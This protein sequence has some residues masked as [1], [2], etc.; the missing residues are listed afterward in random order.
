MYGLVGEHE[1]AAEYIGNA[2]ALAEKN[3]AK[4]HPFLGIVYGFAGDYYAEINNFS[5]HINYSN[6]AI[7]IFRKAYG[8][9]SAR[10]A[11]ILAKMGS[12]SAKNKRLD[13][14]IT[15]YDQALAIYESKMGKQNPKTAS[16]HHALGMVFDDQH[17]F[18]EA[19]V[20]YQKAFA[21]ISAS[22]KDTTSLYPNPR[23]DEL[24]S[25]S[26]ALKIADSKGQT[27]FKK[28][29]FEKNDHSALK[30]SLTTYQFAVNLIDQ[31]NAEYKIE[32]A[33]IAL[34]NESRKI[35]S[36]ALRVAHQLYVLTKDQMFLNEAFIISEKSKSALLSENLRDGRAKTIAGVPD[37][38]IA[39]ENDIKVELAFYQNGMYQA[40]KTNEPD[41]IRM[42]EKNIFETQQKYN[43][44][45]E[46]LEERF[47]AYFNIKYNSKAMDIA[48]VRDLLP[49]ENTAVVE[50]FT[51]DSSVFIFSI[52]KNSARLE[53]RRRS[54]TLEEVFHNYR[55]SLTDA[56][57]IL[58]FRKQADELYTQSAYSLYEFLLQPIFETGEKSIQK[59][60]I[61]PDDVLAQL[62]FG[63]LLTKKTDNENSEYKTLEYL[64]QKY[65]ISYAYSAA[66]IRNESVR[67]KRS[68]HSFAGFAPSYSG[69]QFANL[70]TVLHSMAYLV[71]R[72]GNLSLPGAEEEV[73]HISEFMKGKSWLRENATETNFKKHAGDYAILHLAMHS[74]LNNENPEY[75]ELLFHQEKDLL[76]DG[77][78]KVSEIYNLDLNADLVVLSACSSGY[79]RIQ[80]GEG[81]ISISRA[82][83]Y[84]GCPS[85]V[86]SLWKVP[87]D[88]TRQIMTYFYEELMNVKEKDEALQL[89]Q[90]K[91]LS[92]TKD[93]L[94][95]H[96]YFWAG[97]VVMG[98][99]GPV[100]SSPWP[101][102]IF[103]GAMLI[104]SAVVFVFRKKRDIHSSSSKS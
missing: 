73:R 13:E 57:F 83:S 41:K 58:N 50:F 89:A 25:K 76:N 17:R 19:L 34:E 55:K 21:C 23:P 38:L 27:F 91:F 51:G 42:Y 36:M 101:V 10:E 15:F 18:D 103:I 5:A 94:Y 35:Y 16:M 66:F 3:L 69:N 68:I 67:S 71:V 47:P 54:A 14:A 102:W 93:P 45:K 29:A 62:N 48:T 97:F 75:S 56:D 92:E 37:S 60:I 20:S 6:K 1:K 2:K 90:L 100:T 22:R 43:L 31:I 59:L 64:I 9:G 80:K 63:T 40:R 85:V 96:P 30:Q 8:A 61:I 26:L 33:K 84:A 79:G 65:Q 88:V 4:D 81:P 95:H 46:R 12:S 28:S 74:L 32:S 78:L 99:T 86:M 77:F 49:D 70:D 87:D 11:D 39:A 53:Q 44:L 82:F 98:D 72:N 7:A 52:T 104:G 24:E